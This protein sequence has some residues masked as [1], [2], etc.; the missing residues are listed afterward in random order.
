MKIEKAKKSKNL[1]DHTGY[2]KGQKWLDWFFTNLNPKYA[3]DKLKSGP[4]IRQNLSL[5]K[6]PQSDNFIDRTG[7]EP[8]SNLKEMLFFDLMKR[9]HPNG[10]LLNNDNRPMLVDPILNIAHDPFKFRARKK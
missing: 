7:V 10:L 6:A 4:T 8:S 1:E 9:L 5:G 3:Y 2:T